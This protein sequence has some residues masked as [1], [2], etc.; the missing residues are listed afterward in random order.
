MFL[1]LGNKNNEKSVEAFV[2]K[3]IEIIAY[4]GWGRVLTTKEI[5]VY[6]A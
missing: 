1:H 2:L 3:I 4:I 5:N 6:I